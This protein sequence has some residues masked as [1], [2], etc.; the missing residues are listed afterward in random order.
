MNVNT[1]AKYQPSCPKFSE[2]LRKNRGAASE[3]VAASKI[4]SLPT[5]SKYKSGTNSIS[6]EGAIEIERLTGGQFKAEHLSP[7][8]ADLIR[9][10]R[11]N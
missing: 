6:L 10:I 7:R 2:Y 3:M 4:L 5:L 11:G 9:F 1:V 8:H